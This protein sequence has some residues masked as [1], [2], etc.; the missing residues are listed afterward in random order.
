MQA[1][2]SYDVGMKTRKARQYTIRAVP[3]DIDRALRQKAR[4]AG[5]SLN[6]AVLEILAKETRG[7]G[8]P[9]LYHDL[10]HLAGTMNPD[11]EF[12]KFIEEQRQIDWELWR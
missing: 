4:A 9:K 7:A 12:D 2:H 11:P 8:E 5:K 10:D 1:M 6:E 3:A